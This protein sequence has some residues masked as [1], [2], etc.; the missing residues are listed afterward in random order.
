[1][2]LVF[3]SKDFCNKY[4]FSEPRDEGLI[5]LAGFLNFWGILFLITTLAIA[6]FK[7]ENSSVEEGLDD[8]PDFGIKKAY[9]ILLKIIKLKPV[10]K[11][12][13][14]L[15]TVKASFA[16]CDAVTSLKLIEYGVPKEKIALLAIPLVPVQFILPLAISKFTA[17]PTPMSFYIKAFPMR[18]IMSVVI[19]VFVFYT[20]SMKVDGDFPFY[21]YIG[22]IF[23]YMFYQV[24]IS[25]L[26]FHQVVKN[27]FHYRFVIFSCHSDR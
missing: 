8:H 24:I 23:V 7:K 18:L 5:T 17:G 13:L 9:P 4:I 19:A 2:L 12:A 27:N 25:G 22:I 21:F 6:V 14:I 26:L 16:A 3:E 1:V 20:P 11:M 10:L 15:L